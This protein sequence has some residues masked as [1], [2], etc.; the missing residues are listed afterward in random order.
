[1]TAARPLTMKRLIHAGFV[2]L[3]LTNVVDDCLADAASIDC[4]P[5]PGGAAAAKQSYTLPRA[6]LEDLPGI[7]SSADK[8][9]AGS[10]CAGQGRQFRVF[11]AMLHKSKPDLSEYGMEPVNL[12]YEGSLFDSRFP[13]DPA[14]SPAAVRN[15]ALR[16]TTEPGI[17]VL[18]VERWIYLPDATQRYVDLIRRMKTVSPGIRVGYYS[19]V[20]KRDYWRAKEGRNSPKYAEWQHENDQLQPLADKV[21]F[22]FPSLYTFYDYQ[23]G[24]VAYA[25]ENLREARRLANGKPVYAFLWPT[26]HESNAQLKGK[27]VPAEFWRL[28]LETVS[29]LADGVV[30]WGGG[31]WD[32]GAPWWLE[33][34]TFLS[35]LKAQSRK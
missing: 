15:A 1:M 8:I 7:T 17:T 14:P 5:R 26:Y 30:I 23:P 22:L 19:V 20:P 34:Q 3:L 28:Q 6:G 10:K 32:P 27:L 4:T 12:I 16:A 11:D 9:S 33:T 35:S 31:S 13:D 29:R 24:W 25:E 18:D 21:D 2:T